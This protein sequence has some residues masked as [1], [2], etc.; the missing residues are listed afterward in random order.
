MIT[1]TRALLEQALETLD[2]IPQDTKA[3]GERA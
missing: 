3:E 1:T 2:N